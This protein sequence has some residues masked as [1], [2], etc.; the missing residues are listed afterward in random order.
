ML[1]V[2]I[3]FMLKMKLFLS[4]VENESHNIIK[5]K[6]IEKLPIFTKNPGWL[7]QDG[8]RTFELCWNNGHITLKD[9]AINAT[10]LDWKDSEVIPI[11]H[12]GIRTAWGSKGDWKIMKEVC[13]KSPSRPVR[14]TAP[15]KSGPVLI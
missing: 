10:I 8:Y 5:F 1:T 14:S 11:S 4:K 12:Y 6:S 2:I 15:V 7:S 9:V 13:T 3:I